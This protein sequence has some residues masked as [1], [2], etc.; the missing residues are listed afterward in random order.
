MGSFI[1]FW[2]DLSTKHR[3][4]AP[5]N[6]NVILCVKL[7]SLWSFCTVCESQLENFGFDQEKENNILGQMKFIFTTIFFQFTIFIPM[8]FRALIPSVKCDLSEP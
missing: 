4:V 1:K 8:L 6:G 3:N 5:S 2:V 7:A